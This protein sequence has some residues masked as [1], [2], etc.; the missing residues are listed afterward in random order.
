ME[1]DPMLRQAY[2][3]QRQMA[4]DVRLLDRSAVPTPLQVQLRDLIVFDEIL[5]YE[6]TPTINDPQLAQVAETRLVLNDAR[7]KECAQLFRELWN[8][9]RELDDQIKA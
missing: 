1:R 4:I 6:T 3:E 9:S 2:E 5:A 7:V 8:V